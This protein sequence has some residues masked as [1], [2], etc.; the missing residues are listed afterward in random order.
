MR[1]KYM[2]Q[3]N[4]KITWFQNQPKQKTVHV[5]IFKHKYNLD[6]SFQFVTTHENVLMTNTP[7]KQNIWRKEVCNDKASRYQSLHIIRTKFFFECMN[8]GFMSS[9]IDRMLFNVIWSFIMFSECYLFII[10]GMFF[11]HFSRM[12]IEDILNFNN[13]N[14]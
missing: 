3:K 13:N 2:N 9:N 12:S 6:R 14:N 10:H 1:K 11:K 7:Y 4:T 8:K 5:I